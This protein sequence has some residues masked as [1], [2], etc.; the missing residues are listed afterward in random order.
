M[1]NKANPLADNTNVQELF[2]IMK[3]NGK[4]TAEL[5]ALLGYVKQM[6]NFVKSAE[7]QIAD[8]KSQIMDMKEIQKHPIKTALVYQGVTTMSRTITVLKVTRTAAIAMM[9]MRLQPN[10]RTVMMIEKICNCGTLA[11]F[12]CYY[13]HPGP[14]KRGKKRISHNR[15][16]AAF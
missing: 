12:V 8:M 6:E 3:E 14:C 15:C 5:T 1:A 4:D 13:K 2:S 16:C 7:G 11:A 10:R 9:R